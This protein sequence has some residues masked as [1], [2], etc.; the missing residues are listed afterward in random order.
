MWYGFFVVKVMPQTNGILAYAPV[1]RV[2]TLRII[3]PEYPEAVS[4]KHLEV[5][6]SVRHTRCIA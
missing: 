3:G 4:H 2:Y 1:E 5:L 6:D